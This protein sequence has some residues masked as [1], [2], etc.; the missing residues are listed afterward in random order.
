MECC[1]L[2]LFFFFLLFSFVFFSHGGVPQFFLL[3]S[4]SHGDPPQPATVDN[5]VL[6]RLIDFVVA[7]P[8]EWD[9]GIGRV[10]DLSGNEGTASSTS[11]SIRAARFDLEGNI[12]QGCK[13]LRVVFSRASAS[14]R[15]SRLTIPL[16]RFLWRDS[17]LCV[18]VM[19]ES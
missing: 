7:V 19:S 11:S 5:R 18:S 1:L 8:A 14:R 15:E 9:R 12:I 6:A 10:D 17:F 4:S 2:L 16:I 3:R 13:F